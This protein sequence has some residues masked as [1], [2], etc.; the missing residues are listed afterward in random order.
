[1]KMTLAICKYN[2][3][4]SQSRHGT[5]QVNQSRGKSASARRVRRRRH[6]RRRHR[7]TQHPSLLPVTRQWT[8]GLLVLLRQH[9]L[10]GRERRRRRPRRRHRRLRRRGRRR[11]RR[12]RRSRGRR[13]R[14]VEYVAHDR[15][16][17]SL[18]IEIS[19]KVRRLSGQRCGARR[20]SR[21]RDHN[22]YESFP[23]QTTTFVIFKWPK[24]NSENLTL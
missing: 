19:R 6:Q 4:S 10:A 20:C 23:P 22:I 24:K 3:R 21:I 18:R 12:A 1:M 15:T 11:R 13:D 16:T 17:P 2:S 9:W 7:R 14:R 5:L 8:C